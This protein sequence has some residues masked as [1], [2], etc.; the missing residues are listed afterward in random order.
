MRAVLDP[1]VI[2]SALLTPQGSPGKILLLWLGGAFELVVSPKLLEEL[3]RVLRYSKIRKRIAEEEAD[4]AIDV[5]ARWGSLTEDPA[6]PPSI[7]TSDPKDDYLMALAESSASAIVSGDS[8]LLELDSGLPIY[9]PKAF[10]E[11]IQG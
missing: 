7:R 2:V 6:S 3:G 1:N 11:L 5:L 4:E 9:S 10:L 8:H